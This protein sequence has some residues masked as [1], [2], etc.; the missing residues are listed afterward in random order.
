MDI[1]IVYMRIDRFWDLLSKKISAEASQAELKE[2][3]EI[4]LGHPD[5][6]NTADALEIL[7]HQSTSFE[8]NNDAEQAFEVHIERMKRAD[9][10]F[11]QTALYYAESGVKEKA[12]KGNRTKWW[13]YAAIVAVNVLCFFIF[14]NN[15]NTSEKR[16]NRLSTLSQVTTKP[17]SKTQIQLPDGSTVWLNASSNLTYDKNFG[18]NLREINLTGEAFFDVMKDSSRPFI[19]HT[20]VIDIKVLGTAFNV[21]SYPNDANTETSLIRGKVEVTVKNRSNEKVYLEPNE[22]L[23]VANNVVADKPVNKMTPKNESDSYRIQ[24]KPLYSIQ[25][26]TYYPVDSA[27]IETSWVDNRL[28]FQSNETFRE[29]ALKME[30]WYGVQ[31][32]FNDEKVAGYHPF[33]SFRNETITQALDALRLGLKFNYKIEGNKIIITQ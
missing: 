6:K 3:E 16:I 30:R 20:K 19:I 11:N 28:L 21:R 26:L 4:L 25:H 22:K 24:E 2:L 23:V 15:N 33:G 5:W 17:G 9:I 12:N 1:P 32:S 7:G 18:K 8:N 13:L 31:I 27:I 14:N 10:G 29:V